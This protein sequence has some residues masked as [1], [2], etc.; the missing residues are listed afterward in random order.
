MKQIFCTLLMA[1]GILGI[2]F[3]ANACL[4]GP[5]TCPP[6]WDAIIEGFP[7]EDPTSLKQQGTKVGYDA[8]SAIASEVQVQAKQKINNA[9]SSVKSDLSAYAVP[10]TSLNQAFSSG[11]SFTTDLSSD[12][13]PQSTSLTTEKDKN[14]DSATAKGEN[15]VDDIMIQV[16]KSQL[17]TNA[18]L[19]GEMYE[20]S[21][22]A[23]MRQENLVDAYAK[24]LLMRQNLD[25]LI[26]AMDEELDKTA[27]AGE[28]AN[29]ALRSNAA[30]NGMVS[31]LLSLYQQ[32]VAARLQLAAFLKLE[33]VGTI[34]RSVI[35]S[36][37]AEK[38]S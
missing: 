14:A 29:A 12:L 6:C 4:C 38:S 24:V 33:Q 16:E 7:V 11:E 5:N 15:S 28:D 34:N 25:E 30:A 26:N 9:K 13:L 18:T 17:S 20:T 27:K 19:T 31:Q 23:Y 8:S 10:D 32:I 35:Q 3:E 37:L 1:M 36:A 2:S 21:K 22:R